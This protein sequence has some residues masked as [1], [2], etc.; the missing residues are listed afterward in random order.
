MMQKKTSLRKKQIK[1][2]FTIPEYNLTDEEDPDHKNKKRDHSETDT[3]QKPVIDLLK[4]CNHIEDGFPYI[5]MK[6]DVNFIT[7]DYEN[8]IQK[9]IAKQVVITRANQSDIP[10]LADLYNRAFLS[11]NDPYSPMTLENMGAIFNHNYTIIVIAHIWGAPAGFAIIDFEGISQEYG[12][13]A[14]LGTLPEWQKRGVGTSIGIATWQYFKDRKV[15]EL[16]C[17]VY[18]C[19]KASYNLIKGLGFKEVGVKFYKL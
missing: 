8:D 16:K 2:W 15:K 19:N 9:R 11:A 7:P 1:N 4:L 12:I 5:Q 6:L 3:S 10:L 17:E 18:A 13:I 14:G